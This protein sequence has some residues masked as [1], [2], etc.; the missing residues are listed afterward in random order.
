MYAGAQTASSAVVQYNHL[1]RNYHLSN[2]KALFYNLKSYC[3][4]NNQNVYDFI[5]V[6]FHLKN[7]LYGVN[8]EFDSEFV[9][10]Q[11]HFMQ[12]EKSN[13]TN[14]LIKDLKGNAS[15]RNIYIIK[16]GEDT[17]RGHG[18]QLAQDL[19]AIKQILGENLFHKNGQLQTYL[20]Y[21]QK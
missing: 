5:P 12:R 15:E 4:K 6:T 11:K 17:N 7:G 20:M 10:F 13:L 1:D 21:S 16:P 3:Q 9:R 18:I 14:L 8:G 19:N 2:K